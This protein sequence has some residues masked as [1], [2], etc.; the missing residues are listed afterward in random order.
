MRFILRHTKVMARIEASVDERGVMHIN[1]LHTAYPGGIRSAELLTIDGQP[2]MAKDGVF[3]NVK[4]QAQ[5]V[6]RADLSNVDR[7]LLTGWEDFDGELVLK[8]GMKQKGTEE[9]Y[10]VW[11]FQTINGTK[12]FRK[13]LVLHND[14]RKLN[15]C[16]VYNYDGDRIDTHQ[17]LSDLL[18]KET[19]NQMR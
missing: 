6:C 17:A 1:M 5:F 9:V 13:N 11:G 2:F 12:Y 18:A 15:M 10:E 8:T 7:Y 16:I 19:Q 4:R 3:G 14:K